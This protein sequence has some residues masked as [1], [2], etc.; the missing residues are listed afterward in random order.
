MWKLACFNY[1]PNTQEIST[2]RKKLGRESKCTNEEQSITAH[3][4]KRRAI[5]PEQPETKEVKSFGCHGTM[6]NVKFQ[7][8]K[9]S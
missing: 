6:T 8:D 5:Q 3:K 2:F 9:L 4:K 7:L 1:F